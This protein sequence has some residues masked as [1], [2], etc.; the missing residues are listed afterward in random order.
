MADHWQPGE[1]GAHVLMEA[2]K[3]KL[4]NHENHRNRPDIAGTSRLSPTSPGARSVSTTSG[5]TWPQAAIQSKTVFCASLAGATARIGSGTRWLSPI[6]PKM[7]AT[8]K[9]W[10]DQAPMRHL[11][12]VSST[13]PREGSPAGAGDLQSPG[14]ARS[15]LIR[16]CANLSRGILPAA[17]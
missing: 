12:S 5:G 9:G 2:L 3:G 17:I 1:A 10:Q 16:T 4:T 15:A 11:I 13:R 14:P 8:G 7:P 6:S